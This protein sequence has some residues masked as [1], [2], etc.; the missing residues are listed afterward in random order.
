MSM[1]LL[2]RERR[3]DQQST[4]CKV[5][6]AF[7]VIMEVMYIS[8]AGFV[9]CYRH[10]SRPPTLLANSPQLVQRDRTGSLTLLVI[11]PRL[12]GRPR[13]G[14]GWRAPETRRQ[15]HQRFVRAFHV[16]KQNRRGGATT[17]PATHEEEG[18]AMA[19]HD[20]S[21]EDRKPVAP[22]PS[23]EIPAIVLSQATPPQQVIT[24]SDFYAPCV[25]EEELPDLT[26][27]EHEHGQATDCTSRAPA[28]QHEEAEPP[29]LSLLHPDHLQLI[30]DLRSSVDDQMF[31]TEGISRRLDMLYMAYS[32][33]SPSRRCPTCAQDFTFT[34][35]GG[36]STN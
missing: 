20:V 16:A 25:I 28:M 24:S 8:V 23:L 35:N 33:A 7:M 15:R 31:R 17:A 26:T 10:S 14:T 22:L 1:D 4:R 34:G 36:S 12:R 29:P 3:T 11:M 27:R 2:A 18:L 13:R 32:Q 6:M 9:H 19:H 5:L 21:P 30:F